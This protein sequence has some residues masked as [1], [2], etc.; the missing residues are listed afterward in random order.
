MTSRDERRAMSR[1]IDV[2]GADIMMNLEPL[3]ARTPR[4]RAAI[5]AEVAGNV[6][7]CNACG[8]CDMQVRGDEKGPDFPSLTAPFDLTV[9]SPFP[10]N[11]AM[12]RM[13]RNAIVDHIALNKVAWVP[14]TGCV[15]RAEGGTLRAASEYER[16][17]CRANLH[18]S[19]DAAG[20]PN[21]LIIGEKAMRAWRPDLKLGQVRGLVATMRNRYMVSVVEHPSNATTAGE[22]KQWVHDTSRAVHRLLTGQ[23]GEHAERCIAKDCHRGFHAWDQ[24]ALPWC[25]E[26][27]T[28]RAHDRVPDFT[29]V[30]LPFDEGVA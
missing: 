16:M 9:L 19:L 25:I 17:A 2:F 8:L 21:V 14:M 1:L 20:A 11:G 29:N 27:L 5:R 13:I 10:S 30:R 18:A 23:M 6:E 4:E 12:H 22:K 7:A 15:P 26:H 28:P 3:P 24:D